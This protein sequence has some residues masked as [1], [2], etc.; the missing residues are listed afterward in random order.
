MDDLVSIITPAYNCDR[1]IGETIESAQQQ[2][3]GNWEMII[4]DDCSTDNTA[5]VVRQYAEKDQRIRYVALV[6]NSG[7]AVARTEAM[8]LARGKYIAFLDSDDLWSPTKL[9]KQLSFMR[10]NGFAITCTA[11][12][13]IDES[14]YPLGKVIRAIPRTSYNRLLLDCPVGNSTVMYNVEKLG[15]FRVPDIRKRNDDA[16]WLQI[17]KRERY[18]YGLDEVLAKYRIRGNSLSRNKVELIKYH[19]IL[20]RQ[21]E[22]LSILRS[23]FHI[24]VWCVLKLLRI[25]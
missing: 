6:Q 25:K 22:G 9:E 5:E 15:K 16:L 17:L 23:L 18:I 7:A 8:R 13:H 24:G 2:T 21:I 4:V 20:Y 14:G 1:F 12:E 10:S 19:W 11:Y 3:Y